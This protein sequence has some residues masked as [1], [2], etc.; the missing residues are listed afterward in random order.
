MKTTLPLIA[1]ALAFAAGGPAWAQEEKEPD[2]EGS[3]DH[4]LISRY[5][6]ARICDYTYTT[7][8]VYKLAV[9]PTNPETEKLTKMLPL[10]GKITRIRYSIPIQR[11]SL[12]V[13]RNYEAA[14]KKGGFEILYSGQGEALGPQ[15][16]A[17]AFPQINTGDAERSRYIAVK[18]ARSG[19]DVYAALIVNQTEACAAEVQLDVIEVKPMESD[20]VKTDAAALLDEI[21]R[22]GK[23]SVYGILFDV[24]KSDI[25][26]ESEASIAEIGKL[27]KGN[28]KLC[29]FVVG[30]T[31][32]LGDYAANV[33]LS[34][35]RAE[36]VVKAL[37]S[38][39]GVDAKRLKA[40]GVGPVAPVGSNKTEEGKARNRRVEL[41]EQILGDGK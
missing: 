22:T 4:P 25:K 40:V 17:A 28:P 35:E 32:G 39:H 5:P 12:E 18:L 20:L 27:L 15:F 10:E 3:K 36:A 29:L 33:K 31:H 30:H 38:K 1:M 14:F 23:A 24:A 9:G 34:Q 16:S 26:P 8:E 41:V 11:S 19:G 6:D 2:Y 13:F 37:V 7:F 21:G